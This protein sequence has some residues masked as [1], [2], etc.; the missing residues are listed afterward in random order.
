MKILVAVDDSKASAD[1]LQ[2]M[3]TQLK[4][5]QGEVRVL[6]VLQPVSPVPPPQ[7]DAAYAPELDGWKKDAHQMVER[8]AGQLRSAGFPS[9]DVAVEIGDSREQILNCAERWGADL[10]I[11]GSHG[12]GGLRHLLLGSVAEFLARHSKCSVEIVRAR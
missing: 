4:A 8:F 9:V 3:M 5:G 11:V 7:M 10:I 2:A 1:V 6:H 12:K